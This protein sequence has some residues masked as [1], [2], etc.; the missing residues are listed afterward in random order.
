VALNK[1]IVKAKANSAAAG[2]KIKQLDAKVA[3]LLKYMTEATQIRSE[4]KKENML[5]IKDAKTAQAAIAKAQ[6]VLLSFYK[7]SG[8]VAKEDW[9]EFMQVDAVPGSMKNGG[10]VVLD[11]APK[12]WSGSYTG[13]SDPNAAGTGVIAILTSTAADFATMLASTKS[14]ENLD[15]N[16]YDKDMSA[17]KIDKAKTAKEAEM[18]RDAKK[19]MDDDVRSQEK[20]RN[21]A[22]SEHGAVTQY[23]KDL[24]GSCIDGDSSYDDKKA[25]RTREITSLRKSQQDLEK[26]FNAA[27]LQKIQQH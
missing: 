9:E 18:K 24:E 1:N 14:Q 26:A 15:Q 22:L 2:L 27:F 10:K 16:Q 19:R 17:S 21:H 5:A 3:A 13:Q 6:A 7:D 20:K 4:G 8:M 23:L 12:A 25:A 11:K